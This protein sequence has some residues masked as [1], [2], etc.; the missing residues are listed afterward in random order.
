M[1]VL[2]VEVVSYER[3]VPVW[4][5]TWLSGLFNPQS[6]LRAVTNRF[7]GEPCFVRETSDSAVV[8]TERD[9]GMAGH[10]FFFFTLSFQVL[11][12]LS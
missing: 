12:A 11:E 8:C 2:G 10:F 6:F 4:Q 1:V 5:V 3:G 9:R 7:R